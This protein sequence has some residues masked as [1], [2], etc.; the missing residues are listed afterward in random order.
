LKWVAFHKKT[1]LG[2]GTIVAATGVSSAALPIV[3]ADV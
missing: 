3:G 1:G 2:K